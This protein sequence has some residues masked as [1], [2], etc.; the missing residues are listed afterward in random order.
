MAAQ[1]ADPLGIENRPDPLGLDNRPDPLGIER[2]TPSDYTGP[3]FA[4][5]AP[6]TFRA[7]STAWC[8][9]LIYWGPVRPPLTHLYRRKWA[10]GWRRS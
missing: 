8:R 2:D 4:V 3:A 5:E 10:I 7:W 9:R 1:L 6:P